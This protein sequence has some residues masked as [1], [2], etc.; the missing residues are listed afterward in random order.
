[1]T[2]LLRS[3]MACPRYTGLFITTLIL[4][5]SQ[6]IGFSP[7]STQDLKLGFIT[8]YEYAFSLVTSFISLCFL[9]FSI[10]FPNTVIHKFEEVFFEIVLYLRSKFCVEI[11]VRFQQ[12]TLVKLNHTMNFLKNQHMLESLV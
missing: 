5:I 1:M 8:F 2:I 4:P 6:P 12:C 7:N 3:N 10:V 9:M 11:D